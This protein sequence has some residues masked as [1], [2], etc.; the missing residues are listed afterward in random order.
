MPLASHESIVRAGQAG[1][2]GL[3][4]YL[5][6][7]VH[8]EEIRIALDQ[9]REVSRIRDELALLQAATAERHGS[10]EVYGSSPAIQ[11][12]LKILGQAAATSANAMILGE[13]GTGKRLIGEVLYRDSSRT[14]GRFLQLSC[15]GL[16]ETLIESELFGHEEGAYVGAGARQSSCLELCNGGTLFIDEIGELPRKVQDKLLRFPDRPDVPGA[17]AA[18]FSVQCRRPDHCGFESE[19]GPVRS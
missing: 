14:S 15:A 19:P 16:S 11:S 10:A 4:Q 12:V 18:R 5:K 7:P 2:L 9:A 13:P 8:V 6:K 1:E 3:Q 17:G